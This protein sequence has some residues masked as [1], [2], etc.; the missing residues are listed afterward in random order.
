MGHTHTGRISF[1]INQKH[2]H[3]AFYGDLTLLRAWYPKPA[4]IVS[5]RRT[6]LLDSLKDMRFPILDVGPP[7][8]KLS[9]EQR[10]HLCVQAVTGSF[11]YV[12]IELQDSTWLRPPR[13]VVRCSSNT[14]G[15][16]KGL[17]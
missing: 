6:R 13:Q 3:L 15:V 8:E 7:W 16:G 9:P 17:S 1:A 11:C 12:H 10:D 2:I 14:R 5:G 4:L